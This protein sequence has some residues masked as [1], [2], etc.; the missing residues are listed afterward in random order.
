MGV[1]I[2]FGFFLIILYCISLF[3]L[4]AKVQPLKN[5]KTELLHDTAQSVWRSIKEF[6]VIDTQ[7]FNLINDREIAAVK[8]ERQLEK[9]QIWMRKSRAFQLSSG[10]LFGFMIIATQLL[11]DRCS[12][13][14][15]QT[16]SSKLASNTNAILLLAAV[17]TPLLLEASR[18]NAQKKRELLVKEIGEHDDYD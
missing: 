3:L 6:A 10:V 1:A 7:N 14:D 11:G 8:M 16:I 2:L 9:L 17:I 4:T 18:R 5:T 13:R 15:W 12:E